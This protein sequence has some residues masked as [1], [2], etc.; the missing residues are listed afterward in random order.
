MP[1]N[2]PVAGLLAVLW[3][4]LVP[5]VA[6]DGADKGSEAALLSEVRQLTFEGRRSG[7]G[8][9]SA[10]GTHLVFQSEREPGNPFYQIYAI[11]LETG[12]TR[13]VS[14][15]IGKTTCS[16]MFP[17]NRR[18]LYASTHDDPEAP[19]KQKAEL[20]FRA[21]G[22]ERRY[23]WDYDEH[24]DLYVTDLD[25]GETHR[26][27]DAR[28]YDAEGAVSPDGRRIVFSSNRAAYSAPLSEREQ[29]IFENDKSYF[30]DLYIMNADGSGLRRLTDTPG[31]DGGPFF[32]ADGSRICWRRFSED[33]MTAEVYVMNADGSDPRQLTRLGAMS[34]APY[35]H[36]SGDY[37]IFT[38]NLHGFGNFELYLVDAA[39]Q[40]DPVRVT[41]KD[42][43]DGLPVFSPDGKSLAWTSNRTSSGQSQIFLARWNDAEARRLLDLDGRLSTTPDIN[44]KD[45]RAHVEKLA[46][47]EMEGRLTGS[48]G[49]RKAT[50]YA[51][52]ML[53]AMGLEPAGDDGG[54]YQEFEYTS[55]VSLGP[56]NRLVVRRAAGKSPPA[57]ST[58][59]G[60]PSPTPARAASTRPASSLPAMG[61]WR[62]PKASRPNTIPTCISTSTGSGYSFSVS[63]RRT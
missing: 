38:T 56:A 37:L 61:S 22:K 57:R 32:S 12:D 35:F 29:G 17:D 58:G 55:G 10:D 8:Y 20:E 45:L 28:G 11:D 40:S 25:S 62:R 48:A 4:C 60:G 46:S 19:A 54:W 41:D 42:G 51:A 44:G 59:T 5:G 34:W 1:R 53:R 49:E 43:F 27:T 39:G 31:Y 21:S 15:G 9:F 3:A 16:W 26:L 23:S 52:S 13:R 33:G 36:P 24:F 6:Q 50:A 63:C 18:V 30:N 2:L 14:P 47:E 7:E